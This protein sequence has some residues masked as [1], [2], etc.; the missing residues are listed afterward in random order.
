MSE[1]VI[2]FAWL[3]VVC[4][5]AALFLMVGRKMSVIAIGVLA[6]TWVIVVLVVLRDRAEKQRATNAREAQE[7]VLIGVQRACEIL[8]I[9]QKNAPGEVMRRD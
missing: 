1:A 7:A 2:L 6:V 9:D 3:F 4:V 5:P 8:P